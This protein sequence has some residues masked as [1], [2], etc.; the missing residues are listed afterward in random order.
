MVDIPAEKM[1]G[2]KDFKIIDTHIHLG[3]Y[4]GSFIN[5]DYEDEQTRVFRSLNYDKIVFTHNSFF[6]DLDQ[7]MKNT[8]LFLK[9]NPDFAYAYVVYNPHYIEKSVKIIE[10][11]FGKNNIIGVKIHPEDHQVYITDERYEKLWKIAVEKNI[12]VL[13]HTW[14]PNVASKLQKYADACLFENVIRK[15][16]GLRVILG[17]AGAK[18]YYY[19]NV[20]SML[21]NNPG[22]QIFVDTAG[23]ILYNGMLETFVKEIGSE[24]I[25]FGT[26]SPWTDP[27]LTVSYVLESV[28][29]HRDRENI[30]Y[31][32]SA[33][34]FGF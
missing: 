21:K 6:A 11:N 27:V 32:N 31:N 1:N 26:D 16:P 2:L 9:K 20:I 10:D 4:T 15:H 14:N 22:R 28:I 34:L 17:H 25:L 13:S 18:D 23:D 7:G 24:K 12:P 19:H 30:F 5:T 29:S 8:L 3:K 33:G